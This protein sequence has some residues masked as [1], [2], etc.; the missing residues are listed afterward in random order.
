[1]RIFYICPDFSPPSGGVK[2]LYNHVQILRDNG[3]DAYIVHSENGFR[4][5]WFNS[6][7]P[8]LYFSDNPTFYPTTD[9]I[10]IPEG[11]PNIM[12]QLKA[13]PNKVV[14]A[15]SSHYIFKN[16]PWGEN[17]NDYGI[18]WIMTN[19]STTQKLIEWSME[20]SNVH[21]IGT[22]IDQNIFITHLKKRDCRYP[23]WP[24]KT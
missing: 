6:S 23:I 18:N 14:I 21:T 5:A 19:S 3:Y 12:K 7:L 1:M 17:W 10:V 15:L 22:S 13:F 2:R 24:G 9:T 11:F 8:T 20:I 4:P 16:M